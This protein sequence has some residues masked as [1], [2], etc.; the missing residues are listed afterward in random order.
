MVCH[1]LE[2]VA[3][4]ALLAALVSFTLGILLGPRII[5]WLQNRFRD[6][7]V[8][9][10]PKLG[11]LNEQKK[12]I[13]TMGGLFIVL[14]ITVS[15]LVFGDLTNPFLRAVLLLLLG[16]AALGI[17]DDLS[18][19]ARGG[20]GLRAWT[21]LAGQVSV[22]SVVAI[23]V[24]HLHRGVPDG[25]VLS[26]PLAMLDVSLGWVF[27]PLAVLVIVGTSNA[28]NLTDG[29]DGLAGGCLMFATAGMG[30]ATYL[31]GHADLANCLGLPRIPGGDEIL[32]VAGGMSGV[33]LSFL[34]FNCHPAQ[35]F[36]GDTGS[37][38]LGSLLGLMAVV[39]RQE[40][41]L[42]VVGGVFVV[43]AGSVI[44]QVAYYKWRRRRIL[45]CAPLH[46]HFQLK[47]WPENQIVVRF[48]IAAAL[49]AILGV[50]GLKFT[51]RDGLVRSQ[52]Q[53]QTGN[54]SDQ[55]SIAAYEGTA[56][57]WENRLPSHVAQLD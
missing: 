19:L 1:V 41:L 57:E 28:V 49:C 14:G 21:K 52:Q 47:G 16:T 39:A 33:V 3:F 7:G 38:P 2:E 27:L 13:P 36:M 35:V 15:T 53:A 45:L 55:N 18:K 26:P 34:W 8:N 31:S 25:L 37:L 23:D 48:W 6:P 20:R 46:H 32:I 10:S 4:R 9:R 22:A 5:V 12:W 56:R 24:Y 11:S 54:L 42:I 43:E 17:F 29:L 44:I 51:H 50:L 30:V 40:L